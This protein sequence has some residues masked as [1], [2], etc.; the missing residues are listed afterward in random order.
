MA[1]MTK[2]KHS[3][4]SGFTNKQRLKSPFS[5]ISNM[6]M[7]SSSK[8]L[9]KK[10]LVKASKSAKKS[11]EIVALEQQVKL[12]QEKLVKIERNQR[13]L[14]SSVEQ[15]LE[16]SDKVKGRG[17]STS[18]ELEDEASRP[19]T[20]R[21]STTKRK[22][23][24]DNVEDHSGTRAHKV[25]YI[26]VGEGGERDLEDHLRGTSRVDIQVLSSETLPDIDASDMIHGLDSSGT[27]RD[28]V[29]ETHRCNVACPVGCQGHLRPNEIIIYESIRYEGRLLG[30]KRIKGRFVSESTSEDVVSLDMTDFRRVGSRSGRRRRNETEE[31][32]H[33]GAEERI[34][35]RE[36]ASLDSQLETREARLPRL[37]RDIR[38]RHP[39]Y[40]RHHHHLRERAR[41][42]I[43]PVPSQLGVSGLPQRL[44]IL[45]DTPPVSNHVALEHT[46]NSNDKSFNI[47]LKEDD[48][49][50][51]RRHPIAQSTD[52]IRGKVG[53]SSGLHIWEV[54]WP[55]RQR[56]THAVMG[57]GTGD[58]SLHAAGYQSLVGND[59]QSWGWDIGRLKVFHQ[60]TA[61]QPGNYY[62]GSVTHHHQWTVPDTF[63]M[64]L[65]MDQGCLGYL[66][67]DQWLG[68]AV[69]GLKAHAPLYPMASTVWGHCEVKLKYLQG[70]ESGVLG[71]Q[72]IVRSV[73]RDS[74]NPKSILKDSFE[75]EKKIDQ[76]PLPVPLKN[77]I[78]FC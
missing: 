72:D 15:S 64:V 43:P 9:S 71:L 25:A 51:M 75:L 34:S 61:Q 31:R 8:K 14:Q 55:V 77:L 5:S 29:D 11:R 23:K 30:R 1:K 58:A 40:Q 62:P 66:V 46:W 33:R 73:I 76:L 59:D 19:S 70:F 7:K 52:C 2:K 32:R 53:Y 57:V 36:V 6:K 48:P 78:K 10:P 26:H 41:A 18:G 44:A 28:Y 68:W 47:V 63:T 74:L 27:S 54:C 35:S 37:V 16:K 24:S 21:L 3:T 65:D 22:R 60:N 38:T 45:L 56:G 17:Q 39:R 20:S 67:G 4:G 13:R 50:V 42:V 12:M 69:T 49:S